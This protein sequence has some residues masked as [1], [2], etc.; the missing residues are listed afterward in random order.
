MRRAVSPTGKLIPK[1]IF[2]EVRLLGVIEAGFPTEAEEDVQD[3]LSLDDY[4]IDNKES[5][6]MLRVKG[7]SMKDAGIHPGDILIVDR[8]LEPADKK[9]V[10]A[11]VGGDLTVKRIRITI[12]L[13]MP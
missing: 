1:N 8:S 6:F 5:T 7:D 4:L 9:V 2:G 10:I 11:V 13:M 3:T 12:V